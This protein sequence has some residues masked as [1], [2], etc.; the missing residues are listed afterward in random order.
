MSDDDDDDLSVDWGA[1]LAEDH[2]A[3]GL[4]EDDD[5]AAALAQIEGRLSPNRG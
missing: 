2:N 5:M 4:D 1:A 3:P